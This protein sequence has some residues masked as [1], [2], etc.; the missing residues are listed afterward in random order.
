MVKR[1]NSG[2]VVQRVVTSFSI[3]VVRDFF[4]K[5]DYFWNVYSTFSRYFD[6]LESFFTLRL[7]L[8]SS[9]NTVQYCRNGIILIWP[10]WTLGKDTLYRGN[11]KSVVGFVKQDGKGHGNKQMKSFLKKWSVIRGNSLGVMACRGHL[12]LLDAKWGVTPRWRV[13]WFDSYSTILS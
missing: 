2:G 11:T 1:C 5:L 4:L 9:Y 6:I 13:G 7:T 8:T 3:S 12:L 10:P